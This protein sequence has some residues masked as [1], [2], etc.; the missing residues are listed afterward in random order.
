MYKSILEQSFVIVL[1]Q[2]D[3]MTTQLTVDRV[4]IMIIFVS[5]YPLS[6]VFEH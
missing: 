2:M 3:Q 1:L 6:D 4:E 5:D